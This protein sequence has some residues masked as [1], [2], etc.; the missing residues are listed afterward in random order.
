MT[1]N[2]LP[3][4]IITIAVAATFIWKGYVKIPRLSLGNR[5]ITDLPV[6]EQVR[7]FQSGSLEEYGVDVLAAALARAAR[8]DA[9]RDY[10]EKMA[11][12]TAKLI[13][14]KFSGPFAEPTGP[15]PPA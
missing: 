14:E 2:P 10:E 13:R 1:G 11:T 12:E 6:R 15:A 7:A 5:G 9:E 3:W 8:R 4:I